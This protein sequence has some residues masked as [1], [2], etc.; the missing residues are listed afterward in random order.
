MDAYRRVVTGCVRARRC[1]SW[2]VGITICNINVVTSGL[3][4]ENLARNAFVNLSG[5][6]ITQVKDRVR[7]R[8][9]I[10]ESDSDF[11]ILVVADVCTYQRARVSARA[12]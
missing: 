5:F 10:A 3:V 1:V 6:I 7:G 2:I 8:D 4:R 12:R 11:D 9:H